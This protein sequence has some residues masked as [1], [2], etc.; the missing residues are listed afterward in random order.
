MFISP[1]DDPNAASVVI[2]SPIQ[3]GQTTFNEFTKHFLNF[4]IVSVGR[5]VL[6][7]KGHIK[8]PFSK[9]VPMIDDVSNVDEV[10]FGNLL[11]IGIYEPFVGIFTPLFVIVRTRVFRLTNKS[12]R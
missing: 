9:S 4:V 10:N 6:M 8:I 11:A 3:W 7:D 2:L 5:T 12:K 1:L